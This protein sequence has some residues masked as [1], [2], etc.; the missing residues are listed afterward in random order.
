MA[1]PFEPSEEFA[2]KMDQEDPLKDYKKLFHIPKKEN[3]QNVIY[4][5]G[6]SLG[7]QP[8]GIESLLRR[9]LLMWKLHGVE[10]HFKG[11][12]WVNYHEYISELCSGLVGAK[13]SE[14]V[15]MNT[16][17]I[18]LHLMLI[19][20]YRPTVKRFKILVEHSAF[21][22][23]QYAIQSQL[24]LHG[25]DPE[26][27][28][29]E[30]RPDPATQMIHTEDILKIIEQ[31]G[32][33][34]AL[35]LFSGVNYL[36]GQVFDMKKITMAGHAKGCLVGFDLAHAFANI[37]LNLHEWDVDFAVW[38]TYK[39]GNG[40]PGAIAGTFVHEKHFAEDLP[41]LAGW[42]GHNK[43]SRFEMGPNFNPIQSA[44]GWQV[45]NPPIFSMTP[46]IGSFEILRDA[47]MDNL[48]K[49]SKLLTNF[50]DFLLSNLQTDR[51]TITPKDPTMRGCQL[52][53]HIKSN[54]KD[55]FQKLTQ[56]GVI[57]DWREPDVIRIAPVPLYNTF[58]DLWDFFKILK[59]FLQT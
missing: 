6:N 45:S 12:K 23:D 10:G 59:G 3:G 9:E 58:K 35:V 37:K 28:L 1:T 24:K 44:E 8:K 17:T 29:L 32:D 33:S 50:L 56:A 5:C 22:S 52:S 16:L 38:C 34:I 13:P 47:E 36:S 39:Y 51:I 14:V 15:M 20:F 40:G 2:L 48:V 26:T 46:L 19:S 49:K 31:E 43:E 11:T 53:L 4:L 57:C 30:V 55:L 41:R 21:P 7:L 18:N 42:W 54:G 27:A 25:F